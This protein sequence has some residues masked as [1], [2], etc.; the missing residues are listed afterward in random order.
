MVNG[1]PAEAGNKE[2]GPEEKMGLKLFSVTYY[3]FVDRCVINNDKGRNILIKKNH[4][5]KSNYYFN[6][7]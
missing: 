5:H 2:K 4:S 6:K 3:V 7:L 1:A